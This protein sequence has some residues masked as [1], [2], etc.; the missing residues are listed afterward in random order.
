[1]SVVDLNKILSV[2]LSCS[3]HGRAFYFSRWSKQNA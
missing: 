1:M 2:L 3:L